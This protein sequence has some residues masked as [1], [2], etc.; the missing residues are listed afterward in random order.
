MAIA[1]VAAVAEH[2]REMTVAP[3]SDIF[4]TALLNLD[5][6]TKAFF[7][8]S[9]ITAL[10]YMGSCQ[11][12]GPFLGTVNI[13]C[14]NIIRTQKRPIILRTAHIDFAEPGNTPQMPESSDSH[15]PW[16]KVL[17]FRV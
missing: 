7:T 2:N 13:R 3:R 14:R 4:S 8:L 16:A 9:P 12:Y 10:A 6:G 11:N 17:G 1:E 15:R 5:L